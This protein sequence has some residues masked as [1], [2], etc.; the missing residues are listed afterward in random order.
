MQH[1]DMKGNLRYDFVLSNMLDIV[2]HKIVYSKN[3]I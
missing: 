2:S 3:H 1:E